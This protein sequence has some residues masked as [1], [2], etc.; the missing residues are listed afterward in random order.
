MPHIKFLPNILLWLITWPYY[1][2]LVRYT[3]EPLNCI[4]RPQ[5]D[6]EQLLQDV[7]RFAL[8]K[9]TEF[10]YVAFAS[11]PSHGL[12]WP[13]HPGP[14]RGYYTR[15]S[16]FTIGALIT[17]SQHVLFFHRMCPESDLGSD[18]DELND[19]AKINMIQFA[20]TQFFDHFSKSWGS[21][22]TLETGFGSG[23]EGEIKADVNVKAVL[24]NRRL[25]PAM[26]VAWQCPIMMMAW[27]WMQ[28]LVA[29]VVLIAKPFIAVPS[30]P[31]VDERNTAIFALTYAGVMI[32]VFF[33]SS[34]FMYQAGKRFRGVGAIA[35]HGNGYGN[36]RV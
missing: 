8:G 21:L 9:A 2:T 10:K 28:Y 15:R 35:K 12:I 14:L 25:N 34:W 29:V 6:A 7:Q 4:A 32:C 17:G 11:Q 33:Y 20:R 5:A 36:G 1:S 19:N 30:H 24:Q 22:F 18:I 23:S 26:L 27:S 31:G 16:F 3:V 13:V